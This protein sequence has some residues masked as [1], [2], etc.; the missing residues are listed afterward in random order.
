MPDHGS[1]RAEHEVIIVWSDRS[2]VRVVD[3]L[4]I[5]TLADDVLLPVDPDAA[6]ILQQRQNLDVIIVG[7]VAIGVG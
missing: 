2:D 3:H 6:F 7:Q 5:A 1:V 4:G